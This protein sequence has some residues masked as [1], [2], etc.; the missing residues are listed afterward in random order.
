[1]YYKLDVKQ[2]LLY[3]PI[4]EI[5]KFNQIELSVCMLFWF[6][7]VLQVAGARSITF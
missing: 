4:F 7:F 1:M 5:V 6:V 3:Y 2:M